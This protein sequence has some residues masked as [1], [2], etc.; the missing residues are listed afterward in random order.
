MV[1]FFSLPIEIRD[2]IYQHCSGE[3]RANPAPMWYHLVRK[4]DKES[5]NL[6][7]LRVSKQT[8]AEFTRHLQAGVW[9]IT[10]GFNPEYEPFASSQGEK[11][12][13]VEFHYKDGLGDPLCHKD[14]DSLYSGP[15]VHKVSQ[16]T[17]VHNMM[18][19]HTMNVW[20]KKL[21]V[22]ISTTASRIKI[23]A[24]NARCFHQCCRLAMEFQRM[25]KSRF[26]TDTVVMKRG[27]ILSGSIATCQ[28]REIEFEGVESES[29]ATRFLNVIR[30]VSNSAAFQKNVK[31][32][33]SKSKDKAKS[34]KVGS[35]DDEDESSSSLMSA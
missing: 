6:A 19:D 1:S 5:A 10:P 34:K 24:T 15:M 31:K 25:M 17:D 3:G 18:N 21:E 11:V 28:G 20:Q 9:V 33:K 23:D 7:L 2:V 16:R 30:I 35:T 8:R 13:V 26:D 12:I 27:K 32:S 4:D 14:M 29:E 22:A